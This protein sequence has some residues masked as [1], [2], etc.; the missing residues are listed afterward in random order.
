MTIIDTPGYGENVEKNRE[1]TKLIRT[2]FEEKNGTQQLD[3]VGFVIK[4]T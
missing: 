4:A 1:I 2:F 3:L